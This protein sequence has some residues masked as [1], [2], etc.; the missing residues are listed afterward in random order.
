MEFVAIPSII[1]DVLCAIFDQFY[2]AD[3][4]YFKSRNVKEEKHK[5]CCQLCLF[6]KQN[7]IHFPLLFVI[8]SYPITFVTGT[9]LVDGGPR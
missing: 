7:G 1:F 4:K 9:V 6:Y 5:R 8:R 2:Q 3:K